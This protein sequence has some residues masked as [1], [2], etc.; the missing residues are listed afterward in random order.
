MDFSSLSVLS[1]NSSS[2]GAFLITV[3]TISFSSESGQSTLV[4]KTQAS[5]EIARIKLLTVGDMELIMFLIL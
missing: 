1:I 2:V 5:I 4:A 3:L